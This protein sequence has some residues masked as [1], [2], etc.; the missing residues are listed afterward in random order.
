VLVIHEN[1]GLT[2]WVRSVADRV[3]EAGY[4]AIAPDLLSGKGPNGGGTDSFADADAATKAIYALD[5]A[6]VTADLSAV[7]DY[8]TKLEACNGKLSV[9]GFCWGGSQSFAFATER[10]DLKA[11]CVFYGT[12]PKEES[13]LSKIALPGLRLLRR[14]GRAHRRDDPRHGRRAEEARQDLRAG[15]LRGRGPRVHARGRSLRRLGREQEGARRSL[16]AL[17]EGAR[18]ALTVLRASARVPSRSR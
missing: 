6:Q 7:A 12:A 16:G 4:I 18:G 10:K 2:D 11:A 17:E 14:V 1:K 5:A 13:A 9:A 3:A 15:D 8:V